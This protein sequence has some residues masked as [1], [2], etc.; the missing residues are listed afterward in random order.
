MAVTVGID[1]VGRGAWAGPLVAAAV[2]MDTKIYGLKDSKLLTPQNRQK[3]ASRIRT[4]SLACALGWVEP[5]EIDKLGLSQSTALAMKRAIEQIRIKYDE[6]II[7][8]KINYLSEVE[9][10]RAVVKADGSISCVSAASIVAKVARDEHMRAQ[11]KIFEAYGFDRH[12]GYGTKLHSKMLKSHG[13]CALHR[14]SYRP[15]AEFI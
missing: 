7:D 9:D 1:E 6:I 2:I 8:G 12:V 4:K 14:R 5:F 11:A 13:I 10:S 3:L 15:V